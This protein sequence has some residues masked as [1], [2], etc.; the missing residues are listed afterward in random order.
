MASD[1]PVGDIADAGSLD[2]E[3]LGFMCGIEIHQQLATGK[4]HS[5]QPGILY[6]YTIDTIP[7]SWPRAHRRLRAAQGEGGVVDVAA[8]FEARR[9]RS[10]TY[11]QSP[12]A[13]LIE[14]DE[15]PPLSHDKDAVE[16]AL[17]VS[18]MMNMNP[19]AVM[20]AMRKT[21]VDGSNTSG[22]QR[23]TLIATGGAVQTNTAPVGISLLT[24]EEDS[25]RKLD[26]VS[27][28][29][30]EVVTYTLDRLG[31]PLIEIATEP[32]ILSPT[33]AQ[34][35]SKTL[36]Q[37]LRDTRRVR[38]GLGT[39][40]QDL[41]VSIACGDRVEIKGC[42]DLDWIPKIIELEMARQLH[43]Y[44]LANEMRAEIGQPLLPPNRDDDDQATEEGVAKSVEE[45]LPCDISD[46]TD[47]FSNCQ[48]KM[49]ADSL[50]DGA[51]VLAVK[52]ANFD[53]RIG[54]KQ[55]DSNG[56]QMPR[57]GRELAA[58]AKLAGVRGIFH[59]DELPAYGIEQAE[60]DG[61]KTSLELNESDAFVLCVAPKWQAELALESVI[62]RAR[63]SFHRTQQEVRNVVIKK[64]APEDGTTSAMRPLPGSARMYP[65]TD[66]QVVPIA[67]EK[68]A[69]IASNLPL[70]QGDRRDKLALCDL[71][72]NQVD[73]LLG[74]EVDDDF[75]AGRDGNLMAGLAG[76]PDKAWGTLLL[77]RAQ[78]EIAELTGAPSVDKV[79]L[80]LL[81]F[82]LEMREA[83]GVT[84]D[85]LIP[86]AARM[87]TSGDW[88]SQQGDADAIRSAL[89]RRADE[90][91]VVPAD[92]G[93]VE[94]VVARIIAERADFVAER[95]MGAMGPLMGIVL[96]ELGGG[97]DGKAVSDALKDAIMK[98]Q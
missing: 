39:I 19:V 95:G 65:E 54:S 11:V 91:G 7:E 22:F 69:D 90:L 21:V 14:L 12:N 56:A 17:T 75:H 6:D 4:L 78:E 83:G 84:R 97:A 33:H 98:L 67:Q 32:E 53:G 16:V 74:R 77:D 82:C 40:R 48:S 41:N 87:M 72:E 3:S 68:W 85:G 66:I 15:A 55:L 38:R 30:G 1:E 59:S 88:H 96:K 81:G 47:L 46:I 94:E 70:T 9:N 93:A 76:L 57:L 45:L 2:P 49:V 20:Q 5:R 13:G 58:A 34:E 64:G 29:G 23:T 52:L 63:T 60:V 80:A 37:L 86:L 62:N 43:F 18:A 35:T 89:E 36:G 27:G 61:A 28:S 50:A 42:Q 71:S 51:K 44:R 73:A 79:S 25:A 10:F 31:V 92:S 8:R 24:L 26:T